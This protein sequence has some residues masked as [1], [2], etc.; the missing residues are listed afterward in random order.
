[1]NN[2]LFLDLEEP[3]RKMFNILQRILD[4]YGVP[5]FYYFLGK[6][7]EG[8][9]CIQNDGSW[10]IY[11]YERRKQ[12]DCMRCMS[13]KSVC[14]EVLRRMAKS[15][16]DYRMLNNAFRRECM[17]TARTIWATGN[18]RGAFRKPGTVMY[19]RYSNKS[20]KPTRLQPKRDLA[21]AYK[22][23]VNEIAVRPKVK[24]KMTYVRKK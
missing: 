20:K 24:N 14:F 21:V 9:T 19:V 1:M 11:N 18:T 3:E 8:A 6:D 13:F 2:N 17:K 16:E 4:R 22:A 7:V 5:R 15:Q 10:L 12:R 23:E